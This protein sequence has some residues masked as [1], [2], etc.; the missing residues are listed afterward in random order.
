MHAWQRNGAW[1][2][3]CLRCGFDTGCGFDDLPTTTCKGGK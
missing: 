2:Y 1:G 3:Q